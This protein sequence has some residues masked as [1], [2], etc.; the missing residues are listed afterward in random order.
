M[1]VAPRTPF[2]RL[3]IVVVIAIAARGVLLRLTGAEIAVL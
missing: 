1:W 2:L 3:G